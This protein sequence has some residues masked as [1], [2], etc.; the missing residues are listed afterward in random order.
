MAAASARLEQL[1]DRAISLE[2][3]PASTVNSPQF[4]FR[5]EM[6]RRIRSEYPSLAR[7][8]LDG[9]IDETGLRQILWTKS[10]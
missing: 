7:A 5:G 1:I 6:K 10:K 2:G 4:D 3:I 9:S 8:S